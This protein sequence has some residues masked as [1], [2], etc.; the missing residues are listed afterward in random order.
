MKLFGY[1]CELLLTFF[2][3]IQRFFLRFCLHFIEPKTDKLLKMYLLL[4]HE[5]RASF[6]YAASQNLFGG[7]HPKN[8][9]NYRVE[10]FE[11]HVDENEVVIDIACGTGAILNKLSD[12]IKQGIGFEKFPPNLE[13]CRINM[14]ANLEFIEADIFTFDYENFQKRTGYTCAI[15]SHILEHIE[16]PAKLLNKVN[17]HKVLVCVPSQEN[18]LAQLKIQLYLPYL[19]DRT[20]FREYTR[21]MLMQELEEAGYKVDNIGFNAEGEIVCAAIKRGSKVEVRVDKV[22]EVQGSGVAGR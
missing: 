5:T 22:E 11:E 20:H 8:V 2:L 10:F 9:F 14:K 12:K 15:F 1:I 4:D 7:L 16:E 3:I 6:I 13:L 17:A 21:K 18:W 19:T